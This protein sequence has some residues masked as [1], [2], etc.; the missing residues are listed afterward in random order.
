MYRLFTKKF[1]PKMESYPTSISDYIEVNND[2]IE[3]CKVCQKSYKGAYRST[4]LR[5]LF[6]H[7]E[8]SHLKLRSYVC[9]YCSHTF[10]S[11]TQKASHVSLK[12]REEH[13]YGRFNR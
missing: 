11:K 2:K 10:N 12:H 3:Q 8:R 9:D 6:D 13:K 5:L 1:F 7:I 4:R